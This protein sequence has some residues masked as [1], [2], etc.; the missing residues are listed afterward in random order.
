MRPSS[1][2]RAHEHRTRSQPLARARPRACTRVRARSPLGRARTAP[3]RPHGRV[4]A[5]LAQLR[6]QLLAPLVQQAHLD[7]SFAAAELALLLR[8]RLDV[9]RAALAEAA[10]PHHQRV[11]LLPVNV[12]RREAL[13]GVEDAHGL[14]CPRLVLHQDRV[15]RQRRRLDGGMLQDEFCRELLHLGRD[16]A[17]GPRAPRHRQP[18]AVVLDRGEPA[19]LALVEPAPGHA[20]AHSQSGANIAPRLLARGGGAA[21]EREGRLGCSALVV[22]HWAGALLSRRP[23]ADGG[24]RTRCRASS[25]SRWPAARCALPLPRRGRGAD[26]VEVGAHVGSDRRLGARLR[27]R[28]DT[29]SGGRGAH[30]WVLDHLGQR[31]G[32]PTG[33]GW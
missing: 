19:L 32:A 27:R 31:G 17:R 29:S 28:P 25:S 24:W 1:R 30:V 5:R 16:R 10:L 14:L 23:C 6:A 9:A 4:V 26:R 18:L 22:G 33:R 12:D 7:V 8:Q 20:R 21:Q 2:A 3:A 15:V 11:L 13:L